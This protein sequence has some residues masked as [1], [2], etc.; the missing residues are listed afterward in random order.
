MTYVHRGLS[1]ESALLDGM[2]RIWE[3]DENVLVGAIDEITL[4]V[5]PYNNA[6]DC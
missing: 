2:M 3:G 6:W 5:T 4:T 1:F